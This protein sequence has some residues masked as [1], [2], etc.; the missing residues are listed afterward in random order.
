MSDITRA[1][2]CV[3]ACAEAFRGDGEILASPMGTIPMIAARLAKLTFEPDLVMTDGVAALRADVDAVGGS[4][5]VV[6]EGTMP[7]RRI[8][9]WVWWGRRHVMMGASQIDAFGNQNISAVGD[10]NRPKVQLL[11]ARGAPGNTICHPTSYWVA[12]QTNRVFVPKVDFVSGVGYDR[13][14]ELGDSGR[15]IDIRRVVTDLAVFDFA[16]PDRRMRLASL[17]PGI[18]VDDVKAATGFEL[19]IADDVPTTRMPTEEELRLIREVIDPKGLRLRE[20][21]A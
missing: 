18:T 8:F 10:W 2:V 5:P 14:A 9:D 11:G 20:V 7:Y 17:H 19:T 1:D 13:A 3:V 15:F 12:K 4:R 21:P 16:T 6:V